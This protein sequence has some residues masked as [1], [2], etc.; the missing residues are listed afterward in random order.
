MRDLLGGIPMSMAVVDEGF[1]VQIVKAH[2][3]E[4]DMGEGQVH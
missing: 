4:K 1:S 2:A 3:R